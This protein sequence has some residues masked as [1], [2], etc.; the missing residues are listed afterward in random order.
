MLSITSLIPQLKTDFPQFR[1]SSS[2]EFRWSPKEATIY[3]DIS[4]N[5]PSTLL[6]ELSHAILDHKDYTKDISLLELE[7]DAWEYARQTLAPRYD[8]VVLDDTVQDSL[9]T[10]RDWLHA[11]STCPNC[12]ATGV[13]Q[14]QKAYKCLAC[15]TIWRVNDARFC[16]LRRYK[17]KN[18]TP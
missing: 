11:R 1:F 6:H 13:Q 12:S 10:Y 14:Q 15:R 9:D 4:S 8:I 3:Y 7:R 2:D 5:D 16:S 17:L 18:N